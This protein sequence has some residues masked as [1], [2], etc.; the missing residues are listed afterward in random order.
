[1]IIAAHRLDQTEVLPPQPPDITGLSSKQ[2]KLPHGEIHRD[3][4]VTLK[5]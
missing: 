4:L 2:K 5:L 1:M 3:M